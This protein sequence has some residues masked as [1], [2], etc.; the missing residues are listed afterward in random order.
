L[1]P[2]LP[3][4]LGGIGEG[5]GGEIMRRIFAFTALLVALPTIANAIILKSSRSDLARHSPHS[6]FADNLRNPKSMTT[7]TSLAIMIAVLVLV[8][9]QF[10]A[11]HNTMHNLP[12]Y[13][14]DTR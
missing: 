8:F 12:W 14:M 9:V 3:H 4:F 6:N 2:T 13:V 1:E 7:T 10:N 11:L 5:T